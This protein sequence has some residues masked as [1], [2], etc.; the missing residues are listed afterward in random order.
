[1]LS[2]LLWPMTIQPALTQQQRP[3]QYGLS[4]VKAVA[5]A[6]GAQEEMAVVAC[7]FGV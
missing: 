3:Q 1:V 7:S 6:L 2:S 4:L 5:V